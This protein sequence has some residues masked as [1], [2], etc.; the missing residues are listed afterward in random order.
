MGLFY[1]WDEI[2]MWTNKPEPEYA[3]VVVWQRTEC[4]C[5]SRKEFVSES[6][7][8]CPMCGATMVRE[9]K[10]IRIK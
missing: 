8:K 5:W 6:E 7:P 10:N 4:N 3:D 9:T 2:L 1:F